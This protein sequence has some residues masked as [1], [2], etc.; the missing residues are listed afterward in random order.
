MAPVKMQVERQ[1]KVTGTPQDFASHIIQSEKAS[2]RVLNKI[3]KQ[4]LEDSKT[5]SQFWCV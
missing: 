3:S 2:D 1:E 5:D 4:I